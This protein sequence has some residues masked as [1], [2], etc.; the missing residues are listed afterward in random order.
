MTATKERAPAGAV[1][2]STGNSVGTYVG[3]GLAAL[4]LGVGVV[5]G[6]VSIA[7]ST[8]D[9]SVAQ[10]AAIARANQIDDNLDALVVDPG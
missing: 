5:W 3:V 4:A 7:D 10:Q 2:E 9:V 8:G 6:A 1:R